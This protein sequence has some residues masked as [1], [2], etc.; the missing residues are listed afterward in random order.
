V[1]DSCSKHAC[2]FA[3]VCVVLSCVGECLE[4][5]QAPAHRV[6]NFIVSEVNS[7]TEQAKGL[8]P[9]DV[10]SRELLCVCVC[11]RARVYTYQVGT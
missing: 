7:E 9:C 5:G 1:F 8:K 10:Q 11:V 4:M 3:F 6:P 2:M